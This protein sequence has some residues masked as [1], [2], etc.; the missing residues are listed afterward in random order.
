MKTALPI[1]I[2]LV[3]LFLQM[4][5]ANKLAIGE[6]AP[7]FPLL[8]VVYF[9]LFRGGFQSTIAGFL[10]GFVQDLYNPAFLGLNALLKSILGFVAG[11]IGSKTELNSV[12]FLALIFL[13]SHMGHDLLYMFFYFG[14]DLGRI[15][16]LFFTVTIPSA[17]YTML[18]GVLIHSAFSLAGLKAVKAFGKAK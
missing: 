17:I 1:F 5:T 13:L 9:S 7:D 11:H 3:F 18:V 4:V 15:L 10:V 16:M 14:F 12:L 6:I 2:A 8:F